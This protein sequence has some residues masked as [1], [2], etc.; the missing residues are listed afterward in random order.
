MLE[1]GKK[2]KI[3]RIVHGTILEGAAGFSHNN[4][5]QRKLIIEGFTPRTNSP[6]IQKMLSTLLNKKTPYDLNGLPYFFI[7]QFHIWNES[8]ALCF[9]LFFL[10]R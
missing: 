9:L 8:I 1:D 2:E 4:Q 3:S 10:F 5:M 7:F 6:K